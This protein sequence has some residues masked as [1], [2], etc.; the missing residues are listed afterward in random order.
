MDAPMNID[1][2]DFIIH[3]VVHN[4]AIGYSSDDSG[5]CDLEDDFTYYY[6]NDYDFYDDSDASYDDER[7]YNV[8]YEIDTEN[9]VNCLTTND[10]YDDVGRFTI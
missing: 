4:R 6:S 1:I 9:R 2:D 3:N 10:C 7:P 8:N 5:S